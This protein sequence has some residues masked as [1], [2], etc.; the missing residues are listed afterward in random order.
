VC[1]VQA[2]TVLLQRF[3]CGG[4]GEPRCDE[5]PEGRAP[6]RPGMLSARLGADAAVLRA[7]WLQPGRYLLTIAQEAP[8]DSGVEAFG[9][10]ASAQAAAVDRCE[11][12]SL[13]VALARADA[14][15]AA[16]GRDRAGRGAARLPPSLDTAAGLRFSDALHSAG[17]VLFPR[18]G[19][20][21]ATVAFHVGPA[22]LFRL[23]AADASEGGHVT[24]EL[25]A[26]GGGARVD[27][28]GGAGGAG[29]DGAGGVLPV[30]L[31][32]AHLVRP[33]PTRSRVVPHRGAAC[34]G[35]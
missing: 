29:R 3:A 8:P 12:Y 26:A 4:A 13:R 1:L 11:A 31:R 30:A 15:G 27:L 22:S 33:R 35:F 24:A 18:F 21:A 32:R 19:P 28:Q 20:A 5:A 14:A 6:L 10:V 2:L 34:C 17:R 9:D 7:Q 16:L 25:R 23:D